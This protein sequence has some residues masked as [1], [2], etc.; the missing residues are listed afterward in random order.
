MSEKTEVKI[1]TSDDVD[2]RREQEWAERQT[3][4]WKLKEAAIVIGGAAFWIAIIA[5]SMSRN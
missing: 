2:A 4:S 5:W 1:D 3:T